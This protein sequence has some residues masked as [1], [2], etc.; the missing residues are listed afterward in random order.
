MKLAVTS[1]AWLI[2]TWQVP[3][4]VQSPLHPENAA[5]VPGV[6]ASVTTVPWTKN[7]AQVPPQVTPLGEL[8]TVPVPEPVFVTVSWK[9]IGAN[10]ATTVRA[11]FIDT[12][13]VPVPGQENPVSGLLHPVN[14]LPAAAVAVKVTPVP[15]EKSMAHVL[16]QLMPFG[17]LVTVPDPPPGPGCCTVSVCVA[18]LGPANLA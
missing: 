5:F 7:D 3:V 1:R 14:V 12:V 16:P 8:V 2:V 18:G 13:H 11:W 15:A 6:A 10:V 9:L 4:P 17:A